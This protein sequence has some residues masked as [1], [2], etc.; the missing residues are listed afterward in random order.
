MRYT[1]ALQ[2]AKLDKGINKIRFYA[3]SR[4]NVLE[5]IIIKKKQE[6]IVTKIIYG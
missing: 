3:A 6:E 2:L 1:E 5:K 4:E